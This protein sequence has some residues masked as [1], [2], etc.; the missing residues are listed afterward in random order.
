MIDVDWDL[1]FRY[2]GNECSADERERFERWLAAD[3]QRQVI[4][5]AAVVAA[6]R[7]LEGMR[8]TAATPRLLV[9]HR[10]PAALPTWLV[11]AAASLVILVGGALLLKSS[12]GTSAV[13]TGQ[14]LRVAQTA[15]GGRQTLRLNDGTRVVLA[16]GSTLRYLA[17]FGDGA[18]D[19]YLA[20]EAFF[21]VTHDAAHPFRVHAGHATA[22]DIGTAF[23]VL[24]YAEDSVVR[25]VV[26]E[27]S[28]SLGDAT[29]GPSHGTV[30]THGQLG[31]LAK[32]DAL[33]TVRR[34]NV[35]AYLAW[36]DG[37]LVF[38]DTPLAEVVARLGRWYDAPFRIADPSLASRTLTA[39]FTTESLADVLTA[40]APVLDVRFERVADT[41]VVHR[42]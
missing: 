35:D 1:V 37:R 28:V 36:T 15:R 18:R 24:A 25:V 7:T 38:D 10:R 5:D 27:G 6:G 14:A 33:A 12:G 31:A 3:P 9:A 39:S 30:L 8:T 32:G 34:V 16:A 2:F 29:R 23:G 20:G 22:E 11:A 4:V 19:V 17:D 40:L 26:A 42:R 21:D 41:V 13:G